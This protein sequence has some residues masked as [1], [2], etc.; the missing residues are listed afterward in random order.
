MAA[1]IEKIYEAVFDGALSILDVFSRYSGTEEAN[2]NR[3]RRDGFGGI[4]IRF[5]AKDGAVRVTT[6]MKDT[7]VEKSGLVVDDLIT[8]IDGFP[9]ATMDKD[10]I[11]NKLRGVVKS[12]VVLTIRRDQDERFPCAIEVVRAHIVPDTVVVRRED[13]VLQLL[14]FQL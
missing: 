5:Q 7:P 11:V 13:G 1:D 9:T 8:H 4:G 3:A 2:R 14:D 12:H 10:E 6:V